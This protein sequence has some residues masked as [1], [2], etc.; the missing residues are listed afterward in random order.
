MQA[1]GEPE[2]TMSAVK[3]DRDGNVVEEIKFRNTEVS[4]AF[5]ARL[6]EAARKGWAEGRQNKGDE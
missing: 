5:L 3:L 4:P 6:K 1:R 2:V